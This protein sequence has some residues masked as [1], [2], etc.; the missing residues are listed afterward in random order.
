MDENPYRSPESLVANAKPAWRL[1][2]SIAL[3]VL[4]IPPALLTMLMTFAGVRWLVIE[5]LNGWLISISVALLLGA[6]LSAS[7][8]ALLVM[9][10]RRLRR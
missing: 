10:A 2:A 5:L 9:G 3:W 6:G 1:F 4:A 7:V 8:T